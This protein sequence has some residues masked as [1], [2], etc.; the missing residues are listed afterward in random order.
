MSVTLPTYEVYD[1]E[2]LPDLGLFLSVDGT[3]LT[4]LA[5]GHTFSLKVTSEDG[6]STLFTTT[7]GF[8]G[9]TGSGAPPTGTPNLVK[10][11]ATSG[12]LASLTAN[13]RYRAQ[14]AITRSSDS[15]VRYFEFYL[16]VR[17]VY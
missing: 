8:T 13:T 15:R 4:G 10:Q 2:S 1:G 11:W 14:L 12:E 6:S 7:T 3:L 16:Y 17:P 9:Q 5:T